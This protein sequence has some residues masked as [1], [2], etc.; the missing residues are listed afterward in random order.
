[1][2]SLNVNGKAQR[3]DAPPSPAHASARGRSAPISSIARRSGRAGDLPVARPRRDTR[4][5]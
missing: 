2:I 4:P 1:M 5:A 3:V